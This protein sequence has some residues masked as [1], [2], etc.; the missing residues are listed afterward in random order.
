MSAARHLPDLAELSLFRQCSKAELNQ[1]RALLTPVELPAGH[2]LWRDGDFPREFGIVADGQV[3][4]TDATGRQVAMLGAGEIVGEMALM[5]GQ[6][7]R[8]T[9]STLT[10]VVLYVGNPTELASLLH[11]AP[12]VGQSVR[13]TVAARRAA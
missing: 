13:A 11:V 12:S 8:G 1:A 3:V 7:R 2:V 4:V 5:G 10:P 6:R 9:V